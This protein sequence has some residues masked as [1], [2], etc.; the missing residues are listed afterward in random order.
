L[1]VIQPALFSVITKFPAFREKVIRLFKHSEEFKEVCM[2]YQEC[3]KALQHW[4]RFP[5]EEAWNRKTEYENLLAEL[6]E[7]IAQSLE[8][9]SPDTDMLP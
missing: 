4:S 8:Q 2:D 7:E 9:N 6:E 3:I 5:D 1:N